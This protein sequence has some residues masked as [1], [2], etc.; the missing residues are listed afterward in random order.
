ME[1]AHCLKC[2]YE[3]I[4]RV[5]DPKKCPK[6]KT[7]NWAGKELKEKVC[8][9]C[10]RHFF[11]LHTHHIN[12]NHS[13]DRKVNK[14]NICL[15]CHSAIHTGTGRKRAQ[16]YFLKKDIIEELTKYRNKLK[17]GRQDV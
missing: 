8:A 7:Y 11:E 1:K 9:I 10:K 15:D 4:I 2:G 12:G 3:W 17:T 6:C 5:D 16:R 13:D 14:I